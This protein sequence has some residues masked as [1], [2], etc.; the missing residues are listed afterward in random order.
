M[1]VKSWDY[2]TNSVIY[3]DNIYIYETNTW[4][5]DYSIQKNKYQA[6]KRVLRY[7]NPSI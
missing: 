4:V 3:D 6:L 5:R 2:K 7:L 1:A